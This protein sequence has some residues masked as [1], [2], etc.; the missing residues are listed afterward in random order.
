M[1]NKDKILNIILKL[2]EEAMDLVRYDKINKSYHEGQREAYDKVLKI[3][4]E[5]L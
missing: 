3:L 2:W 5:E 4:K 1:N